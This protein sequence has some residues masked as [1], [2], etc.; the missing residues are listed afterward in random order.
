MTDVSDLKKFIM[1]HS[2]DV[3]KKTDKKG[4]NLLGLSY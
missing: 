1:R 4:G 2:D 3:I